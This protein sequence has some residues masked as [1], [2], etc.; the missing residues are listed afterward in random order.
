M[1]EAIRLLAMPAESVPFDHATGK[2]ASG[3][4]FYAMRSCEYLKASGS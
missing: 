4:Y 2:L 1:P 3:S